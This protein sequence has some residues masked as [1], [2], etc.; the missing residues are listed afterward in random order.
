AQF[1]KEIEEDAEKKEQYEFT[2]SV[3]QAV[4][5]RGEKLKAMAEFQKEMKRGNR[6]VWLWVSSVAAVL[7]VGFF[8][9]N[10][11]LVEHSPTDNVRGGE[12]DVFEK[13]APVDRNGNDSTAA[14]TIVL[15]HE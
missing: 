6:N 13:A 5:S 2:K 10:S 15:K 8:T 3:K 4:T 12:N 14:D 9:V 7:V 1:L 11:L